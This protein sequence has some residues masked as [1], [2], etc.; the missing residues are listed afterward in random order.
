[1]GS[2]PITGQ[3]YVKEIRFLNLLTAR[4]SQMYE[5]FKHDDGQDVEEWEEVQ[6]PSFFNIIKFRSKDELNYFD[7]ARPEFWNR[8]VNGSFEKS[9]ETD[10]S[11]SFI[12][13][14]PLTDDNFR[15]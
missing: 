7:P 15:R 10:S 11:A 3:Q 6:V 8:R 12:P 13:P 2:S 4:F 14:D 5:H 1:M 9:Q